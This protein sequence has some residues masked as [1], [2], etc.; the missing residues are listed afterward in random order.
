[1]A[2]KLTASRRIGIVTLAALGALALPAAATAS[3][4]VTPTAAADCATLFA[5][6]DEIDARI[7][8]LQEMLATATPAQKP[9]IIKQIKKLNEQADLVDQQLKAAHCV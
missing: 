3:A 1:M 2:T 8:T 5:T 6:S 7:T 4:S 9:G